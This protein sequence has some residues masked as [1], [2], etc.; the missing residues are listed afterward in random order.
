MIRAGIVD[1]DTSHAVEF[2]KRF[3]HID[4]DPEQWID[5]VRVVMGYPGTSLITS[6]EV[7]DEY[8]SVLRDK[9]RIEIVDRPEDMIGQIDAV[10]IESQG[11][12]VHLKRAEPFLKAG[13]STFIDEPF[14]CSL[15]DAKE[16][17]A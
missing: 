5:G 12:A 3:N 7:L 15:S 13:I 4:V 16:L 11:G 17:A 10:L 14:T 1:F 6:K 9:Y 8:T 2:T